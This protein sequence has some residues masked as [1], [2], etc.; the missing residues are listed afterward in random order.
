MFNLAGDYG[1]AF[2]ESFHDNNVFSQYLFNYWQ[3]TDYYGTWPGQPIANVPKSLYDKKVQSDWTQK[4]FEFGTLNLPN[5]AYANAAHKNGAKS[6]AM[7]FYSDND[8][9]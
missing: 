6:I 7:I 5:A 8:R 9:G 1:N 3:Y 4:W 2:F